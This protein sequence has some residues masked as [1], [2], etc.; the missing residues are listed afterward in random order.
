M[1]YKLTNFFTI[2]HTMRA[3][4]RFAGHHHIVLY[5]RIQNKPLFLPIFWNKGNAP[6]HGL[7]RR[8]HLNG[9]T[10]Q[11]QLPAVIRERSKQRFHY[12]CAP[13]SYKSCN[14]QN[15]TLVQLKAD[16]LVY[17]LLAKLAHLQNG[18][19]KQG[20]ALGIVGAQRASNHHANQLFLG[21]SPLTVIQRAD[22]FSIPKHGNTV[23]KRQH[24]F[25]AVR[26][27]DDSH[28]A[29]PQGAD[30]FKQALA[31]PLGQNGCRLI[32]NQNFRIVKQ[33]L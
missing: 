2:Q 8:T 32:Q 22:I 29:F 24:L 15:L 6:V 33:G 23:R 4:L 14:A 7:A 19:A 17:A 20:R 30:H 16:I 27:I 9:F 25:K 5:G 1:A 10:I 31:F 12:F 11:K 13:R 18:F 26:N 21:Y 28:A 3:Y